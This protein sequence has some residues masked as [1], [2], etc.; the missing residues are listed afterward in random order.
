VYEA[1]GEAYDELFSGPDAL[2]TDDELATVDRVDSRL[3]RERGEGV[4]GADEYAIL[5]GG[6]MEEESTPHV[7]CTYYPQVPEYAPSGAPLID[8]ETRE[9]FN[10]ALWDYAERVVELVQARLESFVWSSEV[11]TWAE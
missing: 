3:T 1:R 11:E 7:V 6:A 5:P 10:D 4:W 8:G 9:R 2:L